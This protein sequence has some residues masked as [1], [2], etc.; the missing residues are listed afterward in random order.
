MLEL[1]LR[2]PRVHHWLMLERGLVPPAKRSFSPRQREVV[3]HLL[4]P[5]TEKAIAEELALS[6]GA[7]HNYVT[8]IYKNMGVGSRH[9]LVQCWLQELPFVDQHPC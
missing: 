8:D 7:L 2:F 6:K 4:G 3:Q 1:L 5:Q 9:E